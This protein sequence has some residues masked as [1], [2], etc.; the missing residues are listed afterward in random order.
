MAPIL[1]SPIRLTGCLGTIE[2]ARGP[3]PLASAGVDGRTFWTLACA[4]ATFLSMRGRGLS[5]LLPRICGLFLYI[6]A[7]P[8]PLSGPVGAAGWPV[9]ESI[10]AL[11]PY[12]PPGPVF[13]G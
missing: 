5:P 13:F 11:L 1:R 9:R 4:I 2:V 6:A 12:A 8:L 10:R 7:L 3:M